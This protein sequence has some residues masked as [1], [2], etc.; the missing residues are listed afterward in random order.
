M[1]KEIES[2]F[3]IKRT[4][5]KTLRKAVRSSS[6]S[7]QIFVPQNANRYLIKN[8]KMIGIEITFVVCL[9]LNELTNFV[10]VNILVSNAILLLHY[11]VH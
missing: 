11:L 1:E 6:R 2:N 3:C 7:D 8:F 4:Q 10:I 5:K 9:V